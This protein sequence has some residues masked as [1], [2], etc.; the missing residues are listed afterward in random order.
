MYTTD[1]SFLLKLFVD[2]PDYLWAIKQWRS[3]RFTPKEIPVFHPH[4]SWRS[5]SSPIIGWDIP[6]AVT[7]YY[8]QFALIHKP[9][10]IPAIFPSLNGSLREEQTTIVDKLL[11]H[12]YA[13]GH[14]STGVWK[15]W[16]LCEIARR[17]QQRTLIVVD[18]KSALTQFQKSIKDIFWIEPFIPW[19]KKHQD[20]PITIINIHSMD[21]VDLKW[22]GLVLYDEADKY[23]SSANYREYLCK[24]ES[25]YA[26]A[27]TGTIWLNGFPDKLFAIFYGKKEELILKMMTPSY[28]RV[29]SKFNEY[30]FKSFSDLA[31]LLYENEERNQLI[32]DTTHKAIQSHN[33]AIVFCQRVTHAKYLK[34]KFEE[35]WYKTFMLIGEVPDEERERIRQEIISYPGKCILV[36]SVKI[37]GRWFDC[38]PLDLAIMTTAE[39]FNSNINQY[40]GRVLRPSPWK[41]KCTFIDIND[42]LNPMLKAQAKE[43]YNTYLKSFQQWNQ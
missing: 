12:S 8:K 32:I 42:N 31:T 30:S 22:Y 10:S 13:Y 15:T 6:Q 34:E 4:R 28:I 39:K 24:V 37:I 5:K 19:K 29:P 43:R 25:K 41:V 17:L 36:G 27:V 35:L 26:Y 33:K 21:K 3:V 40:L 18:G 23:L 1:N 9:K 20:S 2:N 7:E 16:I 11:T 14:I 38:P